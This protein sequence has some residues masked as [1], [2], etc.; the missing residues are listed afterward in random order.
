MEIMTN[1]V[2][3]PLETVKFI[4][5]HFRVFPCSFLNKVSDLDLEYSSNNVNLTLLDPFHEDW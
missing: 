4:W 3:H 5:L 1:T 2:S